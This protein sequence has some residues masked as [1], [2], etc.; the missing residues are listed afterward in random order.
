L[1][2]EPNSPGPLSKVILVTLLEKV[3]FISAGISC[4]SPCLMTILFGDVDM[5]I[6]EGGIATQLVK[7]LT[8]FDLN[9]SAV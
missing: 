1:K 3:V 6:G 2:S 4:C 9:D 5:F 8:S 7:S